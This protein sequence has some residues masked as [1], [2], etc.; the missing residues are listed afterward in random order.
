[1]LNSNPH[2]IYLNWTLRQ[3]IKY[4]I[5]SKVCESFIPVVQYTSSVLFADHVSYVINI[6]TT[7]RNMQYLNRSR[8][9][10]EIEIWI[11]PLTKKLTLMMSFAEDRATAIFKALDIC[12]L[13]KN[14]N[15]SGEHWRIVAGVNHF[16]QRAISVKSHLFVTRRVAARRPL[17]SQHPETNFKK[18]LGITGAKL[19]V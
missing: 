9:A 13:G 17:N 4:C 12:N 14:A 5:Q 6:T 19:D 16:I 7:N 2:H 18:L 1:M 8:S 11:V 3:Y 10:S 15:I